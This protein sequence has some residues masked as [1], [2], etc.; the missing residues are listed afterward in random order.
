MAYDPK[1]IAEW[2]IHR[3]KVDGE[4]LTQ[5]KLQ[6]LVYLAHGWRLGLFHKPLIKGEV[7]AWQWGPVIRPL[8]GA[9]AKFGS[10]P[11]VLNS[12]AKPDVKDQAV[13]RL[14]EEVWRVYRRYTAAQLSEM[15][16][17]PKTPWSDT[18][19]PGAKR[20]I[21]NSLIEKHYEGL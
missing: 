14:L 16:H 19:R 8:Y 10:Q 6:K 9:Y 20:T 12:V 7:E 1:T 21:P 15:T 3:A 5:M 11:I 17:R 4:Y 13:E 2:F 18:Y